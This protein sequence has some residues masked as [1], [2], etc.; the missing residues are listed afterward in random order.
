MMQTAEPVVIM[1]HAELDAIIQRAVRAATTAIN[2]PATEP[3]PLW[4]AKMCA[5]YLGI[6]AYT[7]AHEWAHRPGAPAAVVFGSGPKARRRWQANEVR[8]WAARQA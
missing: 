2:K 4:D 3:V 7:W 1:T 8:E 5:A 6:S